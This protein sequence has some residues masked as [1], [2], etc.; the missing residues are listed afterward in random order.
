MFE[1]ELNDFITGLKTAGTILSGQLTG[2]S[3][4]ELTGDAILKIINASTDTVNE[5]RYLFW[6]VGDT[7][8]YK[9]LVVI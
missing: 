1:Q 7:I 4:T 8:N 6:K 3:E 9:P 5:Q 2:V